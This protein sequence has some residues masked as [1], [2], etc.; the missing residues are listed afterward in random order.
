M[1]RPEPREAPYAAKQDQAD[2][3]H[4]SD[5]Y[6]NDTHGHDT[7]DHDTHH[8][9]THDPGGHT[10]HM[11]YLRFGLMIL[12]STTLMYVLMYA[13]TYAWD[14]VYWSETRFYMALLMAAMMSIVMLA[15]MLGMYRDRRVNIGIFAASGL[16]LLVALFLLRSQTTV[17]GVSYMKGMIPHHSIAILTSER[18]EIEDPRVRKLADEIIETQQREIAEMKRLI[19]D[20]TGDTPP[21]EAP[22]EPTANQ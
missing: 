8:N 13:H 1:N 20:L 12:T 5:T 2:R 4:D 10:S 16:L 19:A 14:H 7:H 18:A 11:S 17:S 6:A 3:G 21:T 9:A 15:F 22:G